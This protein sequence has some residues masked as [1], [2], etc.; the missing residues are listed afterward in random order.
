M[1]ESSEHP[2]SLSIDTFVA[3]EVNKRRFTWSIN[4]GGQPVQ[5]SGDSF[6]TQ[7]EAVAAGKVALQRALERRRATPAAPP[8]S[9]TAR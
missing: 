5:A 2:L 9:R 8:M 4:E 6:A 1:L 3:D 7:R